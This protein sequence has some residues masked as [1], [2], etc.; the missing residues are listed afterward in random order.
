MDSFHQL[1][2]VE[3]FLVRWA[4]WTRAHKP[5]LGYPAKSP[6]F[7]TGGINCYDDLQ[8]SADD[9]ACRTMDKLVEDLK[10]APRAAVRHC[11]LGEVWRF[12]RNN[13]DELYEEAL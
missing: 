5:K 3:V 2:R 8:E 7:A 12:P 6:G 13:Y 11:H 10:P 1:S 9:H 4:A